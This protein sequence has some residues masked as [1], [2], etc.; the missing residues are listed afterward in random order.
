MLIPVETEK[1]KEICSGCWY[2]NKP[3]W[4]LNH[5]DFGAIFWV[6]FT[7]V[8]KFLPVHHMIFFWVFLQEA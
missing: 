3:P 2:R 4:T 8:F 5:L 6:F 1:K 7:D